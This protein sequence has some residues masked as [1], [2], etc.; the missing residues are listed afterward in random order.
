MSYNDLQILW[1]KRTSV[2]DDG[3]SQIPD[4]EFGGYSEISHRTALSQQQFLQTRT[5]SEL[6]ES[7][8]QRGVTPSVYA[9]SQ[10][11]STFTFVLG[12]T[13]KQKTVLLRGS[14]NQPILYTQR[15]PEIDHLVGDFGVLHEGQRHLLRFKVHP[16]PD[17]ATQKYNVNFY[18]A[19][20]LGGPNYLKNQ[21]TYA[22]EE[23]SEFKDNR[24]IEK[25]FQHHFGLN[26]H[27]QCESELGKLK[28]KTE[29]LWHLSNMN[30]T[31]TIVESG[32][33][34]QQGVDFGVLFQECLASGEDYRYRSFN[35]IYGFYNK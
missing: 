1:N 30:S 29:Y 23:K 21:P 25:C 19:L 17:W 13:A 8:A 11:S 35:Y 12:P 9:G 15:D 34:R 6:A 26:E 4:S 14:H 27:E 16:A 33:L 3:E 5:Q 20:S 32:Y 10:T 2:S 24:V 7:V 22:P 18:N 28:N 31:M